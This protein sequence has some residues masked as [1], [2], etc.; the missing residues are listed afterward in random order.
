M[1]R[2]T[3]TGTHDSLKKECLQGGS[4]VVF[5]LWMEIFKLDIGDWRLHVFLLYRYNTLCTAAVLV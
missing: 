4:V 5:D 3:G 2:P 1:S